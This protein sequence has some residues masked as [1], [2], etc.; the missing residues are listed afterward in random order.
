MYFLKL[1]PV[2]HDLSNGMIHDANV[3]RPT[4]CGSRIAVLEAIIMKKCM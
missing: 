1:V 2:P 4:D 3:S